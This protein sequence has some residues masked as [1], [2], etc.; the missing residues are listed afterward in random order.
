MLFPRSSDGE[1]KYSAL[2]CQ[3]H[4]GSLDP[5]SGVTK[6]G[7]L[8]LELCPAGSTKTQTG[9]PCKVVHIVCLVGV[10]PRKHDQLPRYDRDG[11][12]PSPG[13]VRLSELPADSDGQH[14]HRECHHQ[15]RGLPPASSGEWAVDGGMSQMCFQ[16][17]KTVTQGEGH[18]GDSQAP[19]GKVLS[20]M[21]THNMGSQIQ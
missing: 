4:E 3:V 15:Y 11:L 1:T 19:V 9:C 5:V 2:S 20:S 13:V 12:W 7:G 10:N 21:S 8:R 16:K 14:H 17:L 18:P 6:M